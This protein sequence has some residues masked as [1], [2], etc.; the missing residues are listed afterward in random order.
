MLISLC[1]CSGLETYLKKN[2]IEL[3][4]REQLKALQIIESAENNKIYNDL[5]QYVSH[6]KTRLSELTTIEEII[7][8]LKDFG[9]KLF[10]KNYLT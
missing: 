1:V 3:Q 8:F 4:M 10:N 6:A 7:E 2:H 9:F 5:N